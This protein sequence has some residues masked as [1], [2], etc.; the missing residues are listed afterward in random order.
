MTALEQR[1]QRFAGLVDRVPHA[2][3]RDLFVDHPIDRRAFEALQSQVCMYISACLKT[4]GSLLS[5]E[6][7]TQRLSDPATDLPNKTPNGLLMPKA[8]VS[9]EFTML[10][11]CLAGIVSRLGLDAVADSW[12]LPINVRVVLGQASAQ[13]TSRPYAASKIHS[14]VWAGEPADTVVINIPVLGDIERTSL[15]WFE[16]PAEL[17]ESHLK[18]LKDFADGESVARQSARIDVKPELGHVYF[19]D[20]ALLHRTARM[21]G[22]CRVSLDMRIRLTAGAAYR[23][24]IEAL[25][26]NSRLGNY[27]PYEQWRSIGDT[28]VLVVDET[29]EQARNRYKTPDASYGARLPYRLVPLS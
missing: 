10:H 5:A 24:H 17:G 3:A 25:C 15:E 20:C 28:T 1:K 4:N 9:L 11:K 6:E 19:S 26:G 16:P 2:F 12:S 23:A 8:E 7:V 22:S 13:T 27:V 21:N 29:M 14:D 18:V